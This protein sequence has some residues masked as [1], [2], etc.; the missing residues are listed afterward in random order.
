[1]NA[2]SPDSSEFE[3]NSA[4]DPMIPAKKQAPVSTTIFWNIVS[5]AVIGEMSPSKKNELD[6]INGKTV[7]TTCKQKETYHNQPWTW[8]SVQSKLP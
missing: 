3:K 1:M 2:D 8:L 4:K 5:M 6:N 7:I